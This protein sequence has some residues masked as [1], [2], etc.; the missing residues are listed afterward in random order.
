MNLA[1]IYRPFYETTK[2]YI[3][4]SEDHGIFV[5]SNHILSHKAS[6]T[7]YKKMNETPCI[8]SD[9]NGFQLDINH[10]RKCTNSWKMNSSL[11]NEK[12][13]KEEIKKEI[14]TFKIE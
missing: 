8:P 13:M 5:L 4:F 14:K 2:E 9:Q 12:Q 6:L 3:F 10:K 1:N 7:R 11:L